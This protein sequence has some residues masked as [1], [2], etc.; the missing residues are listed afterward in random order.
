M[1]KKKQRSARVRGAGSASKPF[2]ERR[3]EAGEWPG[4]QLW[5]RPWA[6]TCL[7]T[8]GTEGPVKP[9]G[10]MSWHWTNAQGPKFQERAD[11]CLHGGE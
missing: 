10:Q 2:P 6:W 4:L 9:C 3:V 5:R 1:D 8:T 11:E 7:D